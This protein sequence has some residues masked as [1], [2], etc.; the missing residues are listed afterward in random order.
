MYV[1]N[2]DVVQVS[3]RIFRAYLHRVTEMLIER[4]VV[5]EVQSDLLTA[6]PLF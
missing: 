5:V 6:L 3:L 2:S 1:L 4:V